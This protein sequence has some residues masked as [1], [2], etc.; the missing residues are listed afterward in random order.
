[1]ENFYI[2]GPSNLIF[3]NV[4]YRASKLFIYFAVNN[5][6]CNNV[7][8]VMCETEGLSDVSVVSLIHVSLKLF[9]CLT[10]L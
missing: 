7:V 10:T 1:M 6:K 3:I 8:V 9:L 5:Y 2:I 4:I